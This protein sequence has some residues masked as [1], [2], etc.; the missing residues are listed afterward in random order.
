MRDLIRLV[1]SAD[2]RLTLYHITDNPHF[3]L[4]PS[5]EPEDNTFSISDRSGH[6]GIYLARDIEPWINGH[7]YIRPYVAEFTADPSVVEADRVG[8]WGGEIFVSAN[9]FDKLTLVRVVPIDAIARETYGLHGWIE[10]SHGHDFDTGE[11]IT[12]K[13]WE[14][15]FNNGYRY[16]RD[17]R[18]MSS[19]EL[20]VYRDRY[21]AGHAI[22]SA[23]R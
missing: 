19:E 5:H 9:D 12:A 13:S 2:D 22:R 6:R 10:T 11:K 18:D 3:A 21:D 4:D 14:R 16:P 15:P 1:E 23:E 20:Q 8:R 7:G 17:T